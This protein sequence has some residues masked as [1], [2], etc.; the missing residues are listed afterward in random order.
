MAE[1][2]WAKYNV[3]GDSKLFSAN[4]AGLVSE[5]VLRFEGETQIT[6]C[7]AYVLNDDG[8]HITASP[9][10]MTKVVSK[11]ESGTISVAQY[12][13]IVTD[14]RLIKAG[15]GDSKVTG[16]WKYQ[17]DYTSSGYPS[18]AFSILPDTEAGWNM[19]YR[20]FTSMDEYVKTVKG[21]YLGAVTSTSSDA[22]PQ[23]GTQ[24]GFYYQIVN[25]GEVTQPPSAPSSITVGETTR[26][27]PI[28][29]SWSAVSSAGTPTYNT[30]QRSINGGAFTDIYTGSALSYTDTADNQNWDT[31]QYRVKAVVNGSSSEWTVSAVKAVQKPS[32]TTAL[33]EGGRLEQLENYEGKPVFPLTVMEGVFRQSD[34]KSLAEVLAEVEQGAV[35]PA[36]PQGETGPQGEKGDK[37]DTG[38]RGPIG[39]AGPGVPTGGTTGQLLAKRTAAD[40]DTQWIDPPEDVAPSVEAANLAPYITNRESNVNAADTSYGIFMARGIA[41]GTSDLTAGSSSL[42]SGCIYLV[43][44]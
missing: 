25:T 5:S 33:P 35:G 41:A 26:S 1:Y 16:N 44:E 4:I 38:E 42:T 32:D 13:Y 31:V 29:V 34:G 8:T 6:F 28:S 15:G 40:H 20:T 39:P 18:A 27:S 23:K 14:K 3:I 19:F 37:G 30:L 7:S 12:P 9:G 36:G 11:N 2:T 17:S 21:S 43:Y 22:Y 10:G 24:D